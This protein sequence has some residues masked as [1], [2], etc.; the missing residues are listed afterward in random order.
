MIDNNEII[1][2]FVEWGLPVVYGFFLL[3][4]HLWNFGSHFFIYLNGGR[5]RRSLVITLVED[6]LTFFIVIIRV[7]LQV[8]RGLLCGFFHNFFRELADKILNIYHLYCFY[9]DWDIP[10]IRSYTLFVDV[11]SYGADLYLLGFALLFAYAIL[12]LQ[13]LFLVIAV[14]LFCRCWFISTYNIEDENNGRD[15]YLKNKVWSTYD[16]RRDIYIRKVY[17]DEINYKK[18]NALYCD[19]NLVDFLKSNK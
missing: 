9:S 6:I 7:C 5:G 3:V 15:D 2:I 10:F 4:E 16:H 11:I 19:L 17:I 18:F 1:F 13:L 12:F 8:V 14:W